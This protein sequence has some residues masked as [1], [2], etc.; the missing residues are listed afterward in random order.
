[1]FKRT[2]ENAVAAMIDGMQ[3]FALGFSWGGYESLIAPSAPAAHR[4][5]DPGP[6]LNPASVSTSGSS[7][8]RI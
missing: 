7:I 5:A 6:S 2:S 3:L 1:L 4:A 8:R